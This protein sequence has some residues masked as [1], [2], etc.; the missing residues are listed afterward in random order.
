MTNK[1]QSIAE[2]RT[3]RSRLLSKKQ[4]L[5]KEIKEDF[6]DLKES[7][8]PVNLVKDF[9]KSDKH[10]QNGQAISP[11]ASNLVSTVLDLVITK[12]LF[13]KNSYIKKF[14]SSYLIHTT[15]PTVIQ[16]FGPT[17]VTSL[18]SLIGEFLHKK[19]S[20]PIYEQ[21]T[22]STWHGE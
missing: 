4:R 16:K 12:L 18:K 9:F 8:K 3:E 19:K 20:G 21:S 15:G 7:F 14:L 6:D 5:E 22:A 1:Y 10:E 11:V 17:I 2:V 13:N